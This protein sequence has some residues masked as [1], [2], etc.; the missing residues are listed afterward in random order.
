MARLPASGLVLLLVFS[1]AQEKRP[2]QEKGKVQ[3]RVTVDRVVVTGRVIDRFAN[4]VPGLAADD[5]RLRVD[6]RETPIESVE[7]IPGEQRPPRSAVETTTGQALEA[8]PPPKISAAGQQAPAAPSRTIVMLFQWEIAGQKD[9]GFVRMM[10]QA[11]RFVDS[12]DPTDRFAVLGYGSSLRLLQDLTTDHGAVRDAIE[13]IRSL[14]FRGR[15]TTA[16][17][18]A[19][20]A[21]IT[22]CGSTGS[23]QKAIICVGN[24]LQAFPGSKTLLFFGWS[25]GRRR[26]P[27]RAEYPKMIE[28]IAKA[29]T[30]VWVLDASDG[31]HTLAEGIARLAFDTGGLYNGGCIYETMYYAD[32]IRLNVHRA[33]EGGTYEIVFRNPAAGRG[34]HEVDIE[35]INRSGTPLFQR[36]YRN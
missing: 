23:I 29:R 34:W 26:G 28:A 20:S 35:L 13:A 33:V 18:P 5:F 36:W 30:S 12:A 15:A 3:E 16:D 25:I 1:S 8:G 10:R 31:K 6:G 32:L 14:G 21:S 2:D 22:G 17:A 7:W 24:S 19:L 11:E 9:T 27:E 4:P